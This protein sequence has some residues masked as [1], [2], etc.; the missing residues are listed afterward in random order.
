MQLSAVG[1]AEDGVRG[2]VELC[3]VR[4]R[5]TLSSLDGGPELDATL[6][7]T[8]AKEHLIMPRP[9]FRILLLLAAAVTIVGPH[10]VSAA[11]SGAELK[12]LD[13]GQILSKL[14]LTRPGLE[15]VRAQAEAG[16]QGEA[17][18]ALL[19][20]YRS[21]YPLPEATRATGDFAT[22]DRI[23]NHVL[24]W[25]PYEPADYGPEIDWEWDPRGDIEWVAAVY[26]F[27]WA[28]PLGEAYRATRDEKYARAFVEMTSDWIAKHP[29]EER[30]R[31][32]PV[33]TSWRGFA[34]LDIQTGIRADNLCR[35][36]LVFIHAEAFTPD[37]LARLLASLYDHQVK[38][39]KIPMG[40]VHNKAIFEQR[41]FVNVAHTFPEFRDSR[42]W[43]ELALERSRENFLAQTTAD[44]VQREW[45]FGYNLGVLQ[46]AVD[47]L[48]R[49]ESA[50]IAVPD[51]YRDRIR[52][53]YDYLFAIG[54]P[55]LA[56][57]MFGDAS[58]SVG[59]SK[60]RTGWPLYSFLT[61]ATELFGDPK[62]AAR[63]KLDTS[64]LPEQT[65]YAFTEAG[66]YVMRDRWGPEQIYFAL[67]CSPKGIS[68]HDQPDNGTFELCAF[69]RWLMPDSGFYTYGH[70]PAGRRWHRQTRVHQ[71][72]T[73]DGKDAQIA[74]RHLGW[75]ETPEYLVATVENGSYP[76]LVHRR[77]VWF[78]DR[79]FFVLLDEAIG[80]AQGTLELHFQLA[81]GEAEI[82]APQ[83]WAATALEDANVLVWAPPEA[84]ISM[85][86]EEGWYACRYG[87]R[88]P[89]KA[90]CYRHAQAVPAAFLTVV[91]P[92]RGVERPKVAAAI[93]EGYEVGGNRAEV[94]VEL[95]S[96]RWRLQRML[97]D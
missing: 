9:F 79:R 18:E 22:A 97:D 73:L 42:R 90:V 19:A 24:Q 60:D 34:W 4:G 93:A 46:D 89:R 47:I 29:L 28:G 91:V 43:M 78:V 40:V 31:V 11:D 41:G 68:G 36:F 39:E 30:G 64:A 56:G 65:C 20:Y 96:G 66:M 50:G 26:R 14:D 21:K 7:T 33:Y 52:K 13:P 75:C 1:D 2:V 83:H 62:Y 57:P 27:Y 59:R 12:S 72:L 54:T 69:G 51:D 55:E 74:G 23:V 82:N 87:H 81:P 37:F 16:R 63:A 92:Y 80:N 86:E 70:D 94:S 88:E 85:S 61:E 25:G 45:S 5:H 53:M 15:A 84:S 76:G 35:V 71:T 95:G 17:L 77:T 48:K 6:T 38:T 32:H 44:G 58:R 49:V 10:A 8:S 67:H 3:C